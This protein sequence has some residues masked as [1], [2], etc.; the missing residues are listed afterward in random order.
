MLPT[1]TDGATARYG[2]A[3]EQKIQPNAGC[4]FGTQAI[5]LIMQSFKKLIQQA[6][7]LA[8]TGDGF[9]GHHEYCQYIQ[10]MHA[11]AK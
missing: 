10:C 1:H 9:G 2:L 8:N 5:V 4:L 3:I 11:K 6:G 7:R